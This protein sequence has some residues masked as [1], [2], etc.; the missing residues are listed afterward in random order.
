VL[1]RLCPECG[2]DSGA[3]PLRDADRLLTAAVAQ[4]SRALQRH[5]A[6]V[7]PTPDTWSPL[8]YAC[9]VRDTCDVFRAR[10]AMVLATDDPTFA[11]WDQ[12]ATAVQERYAEQDPVKVAGELDV[13]LARL[14]G[15]LA[16]VQPGDRDR[17]ALRSN[18]SRF[19][20][21]TL[22]RYLVHDPVHH[23]HDVAG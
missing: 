12:D 7:R 10:I 14:L 20:M 8:E 15:Q 19:T 22:I 18:G 21:T 6:A 3:M 2:F 16:A 13:A 17:P 5:D 4:L 11:N 1:D 23:A 9:H